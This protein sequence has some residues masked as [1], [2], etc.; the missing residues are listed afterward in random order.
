MKQIKY[1]LAANSCD[2]FVSYFDTCFD[3][4]DGWKAFVIKG[5]P[6]TGKSSFMK[7]IA[8]TAEENGY[9]VH[10]C[11]CSSDPDSLDAVVIPK[12]KIS[13]LDGTAP[14]VIDPVYP[15]AVENILNFGDFWDREK[16]VVKRNEIIKL[17][18]KNKALHKT[19]SAFLKSAGTL[20]KENR[21]ITEKNI[22]TEKAECYAKSLC[23][24]YLKEKGSNGGED[25]RFLSAVSPKGVVNFE[26][27]V[28]AFCDKTVI[29]SDD[30][31]VVSSLIFDYLRQKAL[32][33]KLKIITVKNPF[34]PK[35]TEHILIPEL[36]VAFLR[37]SKYFVFKTDSRRIHAKRFM[38]SGQVPNKVKINYKTA[39]MLI[40]FAVD[41]LKNAKSVHD[42]LEENFIGAM[43]YQR[44]DR[45]TEKFCDN[46]F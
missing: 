37:E 14:H 34:L 21:S 5:G 43:D 12:L 36:G 13:V 45:F 23:K 25:I 8:K 9:E 3:P 7:K 28:D 39:K 31:G 6:G 41:T 17:T 26:D 42:E 1:F 40:E 33:N 11:P 27:T 32:E 44:I 2:G 30:T 10:R 22:D 24:K 38:K 46:L 20:L 19:A 29:I 35:F 16:L 15:G 18:D 4:N